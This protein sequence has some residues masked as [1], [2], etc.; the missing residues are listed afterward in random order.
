MA[1]EGVDQSVGYI[2]RE[3]FGIWVKGSRGAS[4]KL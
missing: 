3:G 1:L 2:G 4:N